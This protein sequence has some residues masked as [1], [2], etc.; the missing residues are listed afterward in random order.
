M[1]STWIATGFISLAIAGGLAFA[2]AQN[3]QA[4]VAQAEQASASFTVDNMTCATCPISVKK[5]M[6]RVEGV[7]SVD[8]DFETKTAQVVFDPARTTPDAIGAASSDV[9]YPARETD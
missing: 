8:I 4:P 5:A 7:K 2:A 1:K 6:M 3:S 9:G